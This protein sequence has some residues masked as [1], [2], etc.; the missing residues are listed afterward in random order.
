MNDD[1]KPNNGITIKN[2]NIK[3]L[4]NFWAVVIEN[5]FEKI[6]IPNATLCAN[7]ASALLITIIAITKNANPIIT[8]FDKKTYSKYPKNLIRIKFL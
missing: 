2:N 7:N 4:T 6:I 8:E 1:I 5:I 3:V